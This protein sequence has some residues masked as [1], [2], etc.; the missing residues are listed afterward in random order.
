MKVEKKVEKISG[1][2][3]SRRFGRHEPS[4]RPEK[5]TQPTR[6]QSSRILR[7]Q[8]IYFLISSGVSD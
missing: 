8:I 1:K 7:H 4:S 5:E 6:V 3:R 2:E